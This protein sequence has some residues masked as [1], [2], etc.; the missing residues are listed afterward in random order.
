MKSSFFELESFSYI[1]MA[2]SLAKLLISPQKMFSNLIFGFPVCTPLIPC[3]HYWNGRRSW[4]QQ[5]TEILRADSLAEHDE[6]KRAREETI[7]LIFRWNNVRHDP[8]H[9]DEIVTEIEEWKWKVPGIRVK[10]CSRVLLSVLKT[11][12]QSY[13]KETITWIL[14]LIIVNYWI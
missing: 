10:S 1:K 2:L 12:H 11:S 3:P 14:S 7:F 13:F 9:A 6:D 5:H 8:Y 4:L